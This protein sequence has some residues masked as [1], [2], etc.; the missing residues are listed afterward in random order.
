MRGRGRLWNGIEID[1]VIPE[2]RPIEGDHWESERATMILDRKSSSARRQDH[3][4]SDSALETLEL[5]VNPPDF[6][7]PDLWPRSR[8]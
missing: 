7:D 1:G 5:R 6:R 2:T 3:G 4:K 8:F